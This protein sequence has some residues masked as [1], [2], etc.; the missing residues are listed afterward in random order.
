MEELFTNKEF[1]EFVAT[2][3][4]VI[5][6]TLSW[7]IKIYRTLATE[8][9]Q[10]KTKHDKDWQQIL[11]MLIDNTVTV[12]QSMLIE[13]YEEP[14][15][16]VPQELLIGV[17]K[18]NYQQIEMLEKMFLTSGKGNDTIELNHGKD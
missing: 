17:P 7:N 2:R 14:E 13:Q 1:R 16:D 11:K 5:L 15:K 10:K 18:E 6:R 8:E 4:E 12:L 3:D 9:F